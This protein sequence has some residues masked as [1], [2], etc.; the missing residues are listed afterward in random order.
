MPPY[1]DISGDV[2][3]SP[4]YRYGMLSRASMPAPTLGTALKR[5]C[6][7]QRLLTDDIAMNL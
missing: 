2:M 3:A 5:W 4:A 7:H 1:F 6:R